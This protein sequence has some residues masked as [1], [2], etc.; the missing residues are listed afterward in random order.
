VLEIGPCRPA[1][2]PVIEA[3]IAGLHDAE[4]KLLPVLSPA[5]CVGRIRGRSTHRVQAAPSGD[6]SGLHPPGAGPSRNIARL[7]NASGD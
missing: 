5:L 2:L 3:F 1:D 4:R 7:P 6:L